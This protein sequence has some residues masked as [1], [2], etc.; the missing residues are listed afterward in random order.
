MGFHKWPK[1]PR[2]EGRWPTRRNLDLMGPQCGSAP[3]AEP[4]ADSTFSRLPTQFKKFYFWATGGSEKC[5]LAEPE[6]FL[7]LFPGF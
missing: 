7:E 3:V 6:K 5:V 1:G 2:A 4:N